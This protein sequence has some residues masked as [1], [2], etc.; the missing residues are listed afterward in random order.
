VP[1]RSGIRAGLKNQVDA[2]LAE[3]GVEVEMVDL[4][5]GSGRR[6]L[7]ELQLPA[8]SQQRLEAIDLIWSVTGPESFI[9]LVFE[10]GWTP[11]RYESWL[12]D[13]LQLLVLR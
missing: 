8:I 6:P 9:E 5:A 10:R 4:L 3:R 12:A 11:D 2:V 13:A 1:P 7:F